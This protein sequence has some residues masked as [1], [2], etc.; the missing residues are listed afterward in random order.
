MKQ[1]V[2]YT[3][4]DDQANDHLKLSVCE[5]VLYEKSKTVGAGASNNGGTSSNNSYS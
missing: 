3:R 1:V 5:Y 2:N 4:K